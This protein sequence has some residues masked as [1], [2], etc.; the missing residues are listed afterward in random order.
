MSRGGNKSYAIFASDAFSKLMSMTSHST[1]YATY[2][3]DEKAL[4]LTKDKVAVNS[5]PLRFDKE[6]ARVVAKGIS[7]NNLLDKLAINI[8]LG[9]RL[10]MTEISIE[11]Y[12]GKPGAVVSLQE[13]LLSIEP[14]ENPPIDFTVKTFKGDGVKYRRAPSILDDDSDED[15]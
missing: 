12:N 3:A 7:V 13:H 1:L 5:I 14:T 2:I 9:H 8:P 10:V 15:N 6:T 11:E 4:L